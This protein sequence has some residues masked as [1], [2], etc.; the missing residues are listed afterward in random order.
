MLCEP[1][2]AKGSPFV[3]FIILTENLNLSDWKS[4]S[5]ADLKNAHPPQ[6]WRVWKR[7]AENKD[8]VQTRPRLLQWSEICWNKKQR[9]G[10]GGGKKGKY[11]QHGALFSEKKFAVEAARLQPSWTLLSAAPVW[12]ENNGPVGLISEGVLGRK[13]RTYRRGE[14]PAAVGQDA[15]TSRCGGEGKGKHITGVHTRSSCFFFF[16]YIFFSRWHLNV[17]K[18]AGFLAASGTG[19]AEWPILLADACYR[20]SRHSLDLRSSQTTSTLIW[21]KCQCSVIKLTTDSK[22]QRIPNSVFFFFPCS[23]DVYKSTEN[24]REVHMSLLLLLSDYIKLCLRWT[25][26]LFAPVQEAAHWT[27]QQEAAAGLTFPWKITPLCCCRLSGL[28][29]Q[30]EAFWLRAPRRTNLFRILPLTFVWGEV[31]KC[32]GRHQSPD[33]SL[34]PMTHTGRNW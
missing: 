10:R 27:G 18:N 34:L 17:A 3:I 24:P 21:L 28:S 13:Y 29:A 4:Q 5:P 25:W 9:R 8:C 20:L 15:E 2:Q 19:N 22:A 7:K 33:L 6:V 1:H 16:F 31:F 26:S 32:H 12:P 30:A 11:A 14:E 23:L